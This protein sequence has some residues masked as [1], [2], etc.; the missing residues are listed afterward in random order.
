[1]K[2]NKNLIDNIRLILLVIGIASLSCGISIKS[3]DIH[4]SETLRLAAVIIM[5]TSLFIRIIIWIK[6]SKNKSQ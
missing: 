4:L 6:F 1:M 5:C 3:K 2:L